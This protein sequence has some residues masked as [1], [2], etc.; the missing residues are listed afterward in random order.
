MLQ[1]GTTG[2]SCMGR[3]RKLPVGKVSAR[4]QRGR[5]SRASV[6]TPNTGNELQRADLRRSAG[7]HEPKQLEWPRLR[8]PDIFSATN[9]RGFRPEADQSASD[10]CATDMFYL[11]L[12]NVI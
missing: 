8:A 3:M 6:L 2:S 11:M 4:V 10:G 1:I 7:C 12:S 5:H 9:D